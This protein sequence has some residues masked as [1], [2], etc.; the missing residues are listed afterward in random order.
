MPFL[1]LKLLY[2]QFGNGFRVFPHLVRVVQRIPYLRE[3][4]IDLRP[5]AVVP[6]F[7]FALVAPMTALQHEAGACLELVPERALKFE[8][9]RPVALV[10][11]LAQQL[12]AAEL[13]GA[14]HIVVI[15]LAFRLTFVV[16]V[17][18][19]N[20]LVPIGE[21]L[22]LRKFFRQSFPARTAAPIG[23]DMVF[24]VIF[25]EVQRAVLGAGELIELSAHDAAHQFLP[26]WELA[27][28]ARN[29]AKASQHFEITVVIILHGIVAEMQI[30]FQLVAV[31]IVVPVE[32]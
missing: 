30:V 7:T 12:P 8:G 23:V 18:D 29:R 13:G 17:V 27:D 22:H 9:R 26:A 25:D 1:I 32:I 20:Y 24:D 3:E 10:H 6:A 19:G 31:E 14:L 21:M 4:P 28:D 2:V 11:R 5:C 16:A 15:E